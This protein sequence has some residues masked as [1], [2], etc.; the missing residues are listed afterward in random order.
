MSQADQIKAQNEAE[1]NQIAR[2]KV[3]IDGYDAETRRM[4]AQSNQIRAE[5]KTAFAGAA[6]DNLY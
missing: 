2:E 6:G 5:A 4:V 3:G 1:K